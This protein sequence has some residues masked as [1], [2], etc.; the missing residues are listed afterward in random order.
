VELNL[1]SGIT[2]VTESDWR[3]QKASIHVILKYWTNLK[4]VTLYLLLG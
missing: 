3:I 2:T 1:T 4:Y